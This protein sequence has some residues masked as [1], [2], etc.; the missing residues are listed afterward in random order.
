MF[1]TFSKVSRCAAIVTVVTHKLFTNAILMT[2]AGDEA[3]AP[4]ASVSLKRES[5]PEGN[6]NNKKRKEFNVKDVPTFIYLS[7]LFKGLRRG[8]V[9]KHYHD[10]KSGDTYTGFFVDGKKHGLGTMKYKNGEVYQGT[11]AND[12]RHGRGE[13]KYRLFHGFGKY[14]GE[15]FEG[16]RTGHGTYVEEIKIYVFNNSNPPHPSHGENP[17]LSF[18]LFLHPESG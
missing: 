18:K 15:W 2:H 9:W 1:N 7:R 3:V 16:E 12:K 4:Q 10:K 13:M 17:R 8:H 14:T 6:L 5:D 11:W